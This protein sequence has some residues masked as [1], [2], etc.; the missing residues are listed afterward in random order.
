MSGTATNTEGIGT[1]P[2]RTDGGAKVR[3]D[4]VDIPEAA[5]HTLLTHEDVPG[6]DCYGLNPPIS[7]CSQRI[8]Y[9]VRAIH[10][11]LR[12]ARN[13]RTAHHL[14]H[15]SHRR[16][17]P[18]DHGTSLTRGPSAPRTSC[19]RSTSDITVPGSNATTEGERCSHA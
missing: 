17:D 10:T 2:L 12:R 4:R 6:T 16:R 19:S 3:G 1:S 5:V 13:L 9:T 14:V 8:S 18:R 7:R 11:P 15:P